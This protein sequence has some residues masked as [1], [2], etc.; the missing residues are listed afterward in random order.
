M[1]EGLGAGA[2]LAGSF[3]LLAVVAVVAWGAW[4]LRI[5]LLSHWS[6]PWARLA[7][8]VIA[9]AA[10]IA[11][12]QIL[13]ALG[14]F[15]R[16]W[17]AAGCL[18]VGIAMGA[19]GSVIRASSL[20]GRL[21]APTHTDNP[22]PDSPARGSR[23]QLA[24]VVAA[25]GLVAAQWASH[26][27]DAY[28]RG[29]THSD[30]LWYHAPYAGYFLQTHDFTGLPDRTDVIQAYYPLNASVVH[31]LV[32][33]PFRTDIVSPLVNV[34]WA[35][36]AV[37]AAF[38]I[39]TLVRERHLAVL[40]ALVV[41]GLPMLAGTHPGQ[42]SNDVAVAALLLSCVALLLRGR[43]APVP[44]TLAGVAAGLAIG[45][46]LTTLGLVAALTIGVVVLSI[47]SRRAAPA[48]G[49]SAML[50]AF[51]SFWYVRNWVTADN[52]LPWFE[53]DLGPVSLPR[54]VKE[55]GGSLIENFTDGDRWRDLYF[56][57]LSDALGRVWPVVIA[58]VLAIAVLLLV[59]RR[60]GLE[61]LVGA[62]ILVGFA[63]Y[64]F[65]PSSGGLNF[66]FN[67]RYLSPVLFLAFA[68]LPLGI[69]GLH[70]TWRWGA[71]IL[72]LGLVILNATVQ[73][74][75]RIDAWPPDYVLVAVLTGIGVVVAAPLVVRWRAYLVRPLAVLAT[76]AM[77]VAVIVAVGWP[78]QRHFVRQRYVDSDLP[79]DGIDTTFRGIRDSDVIVFGTV[80]TYP[81]LGLDLS[82]R[83]VV[84]QGPSTDPD[85]DPCR[86]WA[87]VREGRYRYVVLAQVGTLIRVSPPEEW[88]TDDPAATELLRRGNS[89]LYRIDGPLD[90]PACAAS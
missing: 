27:A 58:V 24:G 37:L 56:P 68:A 76:S 69:V 48:L 43:L 55:Q 90:P 53:L 65:T 23:P 19:A 9:V 50:L 5:A 61:R 41:L 62:V 21:D 20:G 17:V 34:G 28:S 83:A 88:F 22:R 89:A 32:D 25:A 60:A 47:R 29:M 73:H 11:V 8:V 30:T 42:A 3:S 64:L 81:M 67:V 26:I 44:T 13:G 14:A 52:P 71:W 78:V 57:G 74:H 66:A 75:E 2:Y 51:G 87:D 70:A 40:G 1:T 38:C 80:E 82:N 4:R 10:V 31:A 49:W 86:Q 72:L 12:A 85:R 79:F 63:T 84:G 36:L 54:S 15:S 7:E 46:K 16:W 18:L 39:G 77:T 33:L 45:T 59:R 35:A 6:G